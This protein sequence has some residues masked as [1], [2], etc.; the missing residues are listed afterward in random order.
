MKIIFASNYF[1]HHQAPFSEAMNKLTNGQYCFIETEK[2]DSERIAM[3][4]GLKEKPCFVVRWD[5]ADGKLQQMLTSA[6]AVITGSAPEELI[7]D[8]LK[9]GKLVLR[10]SERWYKKVRGELKLPF[11]I[12]KNHLKFAR[13][14]NTYMLCASAYTAADCAKS[15]LYLGK[16]YKWGYFPAAKQLEIE[17]VI[18]EKKTGY[19]LMGRQIH[20]L[21]A[22]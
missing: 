12:I 8:R 4:W 5:E 3:G 20:R 11:R 19:P 13:N 17:K 7:K 21:E 6:D 2:M 1:N 16:T 22:S 9:S 10:Y 18:A 14:R 15:H